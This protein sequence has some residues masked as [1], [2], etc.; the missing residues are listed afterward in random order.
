MHSLATALAA[1]EQLRDLLAPACERIEIAGSL[2][3]GKATV[4]DIEL[5]A[6]PRYTLDLLGQP[7]DS[8]L[9]ATV[10]GLVADGTI[11]RPT[12][13]GPRYKAFW[14]ADPGIQVDLFV[15]DP[16]RWGVCFAL[17]T[18]PAAYSKACVTSRSVGGRLEPGL[19]VRDCRLWASDNT[20]IE[21]PEERDFLARCGGWVEPGERK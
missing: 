7:M 18:G 4:K 12:K 15:T 3:R 5:V 11:L 14:L 8:M 13:D 10:D 1:A 20:V 16:E 2:R 21:T 19:F 17:R 9:D 6:I